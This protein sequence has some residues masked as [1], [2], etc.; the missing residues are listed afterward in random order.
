MNRVPIA[1]TRRDARHGIV[2]LKAAYA[3]FR[4]APLVWL[5]VLFTYYLL[6]AIAGL[7]PWAPIGQVVAG[8]LKP[9]FAVGFLAAAWTQ[10]RGG[11]PKLEHLFRGFRSNLYALIALG[12][13]F[14]VGMTLAV[15]ST[16]LVDGGMLIG[17][18]SGSV[19]PTEQ[20]LA[21][22]KPQLALLLGA[23][24]ALPTV[25]ALWFAPALVVFHDAGAVTALGTSL[26]A[27]MANW[28]AVAVYGIAVFALGG[29]LP[30]LALSIAQLFGEAIASLLGVFLVVP[31]LF[32]FVATLH[33][34]DYVSFR[35]VFHADEPAARAARGD[36]ASK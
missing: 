24:C 28:R 7:G 4:Q 15:L 34:S 29:V 9:V 32:A 27:A 11:R 21:G 12:F 14:I 6:V 23:L 10:E 16:M 26:T 20:M 35:D 22:G 25:L 31:Y 18:V 17:V 1:F 30:G 3:M 8:V 13:V 33:I 36:P 5:L 2:W 19:K